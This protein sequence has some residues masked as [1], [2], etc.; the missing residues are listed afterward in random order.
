MHDGATMRGGEVD[1]GLL[2]LVGMALGLGF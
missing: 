2:L 1:P